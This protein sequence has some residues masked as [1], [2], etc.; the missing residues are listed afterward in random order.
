MTTHPNEFDLRRG[1]PLQ[2]PL[3]DRDFSA[4]INPDTGVAAGERAPLAPAVR[5][6]IATDAQTATRKGQPGVRSWE[7]SRLADQMLAAPVAAR[8][9]T[10]REMDSAER[11]WMFRETARITGSMYGMWHDAPVYFV[12]DVLG[13]T[14]WSIQQDVVAACAQP[15]VNRVIVPA[16][17][18]LGKTWLAARIVAWAG[19]VNPIGTMVIV[20]TATRMRQVANQ[21]WP[22]IKTAVAKGGLPGR[23]DTVQWIAEDQFGNKARI[24]YGFS[25]APGDEAAMQGIHGT[26][27]L[28]LVVDEAGGIAGLIGRATN[29]LLT[30]DAKLLAIGNPAMDDPGSWFETMHEEGEDPEAPSTV[31]IRIPTTASPAITGEPTPVCRACVPNVDGHTISGG[32][33]SHLPDHQWLDRTLREY[34]VVLREGTPLEQKVKEARESGHPYIVAKVLAEFPR[35]AAN[36]VM[37][38]SWVESAETR[39]DPTGPAWVRLCDLGLKGEDETFTVKKGSWVRLG[40]DVAADGGDEFAIY[41]C[42]GDVLHP[43][44]HSSGAQNADPMRVAEVVLEEIEAANRLAR[45]LGS[46]AKV[47]V[48]IDRNGLGWGVVGMLERWANSGRVDAE[49][50][51]VMVSESPAKDDPAAVMRPHRKR[52]EMWLA[53]RFLLQPDPG[54]GHGRLRLRVD[55][56]C[57]V[58]LSNP[59]LGHNG[60]GYVIVE[61]KT[62]MRQRGVSSPDRAE[63]ALL[64]IYEGAKV[65][66]GKRRGLLVA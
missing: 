48:K 42:V 14:M 15:G 11:M 44:H 66:G 4:P 32:V 64:S 38:A 10:I 13:E 16:G 47:R 7:A 53:G 29:N 65:G 60:A 56:Q 8:M 30:G 20:T 9:A 58:Q 17:F 34:G 33:P 19:A 50:V 61:S 22:H 63:A 36:K 12:N 28:W 54:T 21:L 41:R 23:T 24:A 55:H 18:G 27:K 35:D 39:E 31:S 5:G 49:I 26:P 1:D 52:D 3:W 46:H 62:S 57:K 51:G 37:P 25:A 59:N 45:V 40:V 43:R 2:E 6:Q